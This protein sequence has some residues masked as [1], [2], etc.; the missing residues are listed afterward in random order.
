MST[1]PPHA[2]AGFRFAPVPTLVLALSLALAATTL[3]ALA[4]PGGGG[5]APVRYTEAIRGEVRPTLE[6]TGT[7]E[8]RRISVVASEVEGKVVSR[9][10]REGDRVG[11]GAPLVR[12]RRENLRLSLESAQAGLAEAEARL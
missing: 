8:S 10:A 2:A 3:P 4:Q 5:P 1:M 7:V 12:L 9:D 6:L 11:Q